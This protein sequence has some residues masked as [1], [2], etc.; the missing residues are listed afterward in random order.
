MTDW[1]VIKGK[2]VIAVTVGVTTL[3]TL[4]FVYHTLA[5]PEAA[6]FK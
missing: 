6:L 3:K 5:R 1:L 2:V 4:V